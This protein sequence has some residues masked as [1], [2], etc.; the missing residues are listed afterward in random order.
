MGN[1]IKRIRSEITEANKD[2]EAGTQVE[3]KDPDDLYN[4]VGCINGPPD[5]PYEGGTFLIDIKLNKDHPF[6]APDFKFITRVFHPNVSSKTGAICLDVL[7]ENWSAA[8]TLRLSLLSVQ[9]LLES[10][11]ETSPQDFEVAKVYTK[12]K[13]E[14]VRKAQDWVNKYAN[15]SLQEHMKKLKKEDSKPEQ[16]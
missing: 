10:P 4:L 12:D 14:F 7:K 9:S 11:D 5:T 1:F 16:Q 2:I 15:V 13:S 6:R 3:I 8:M